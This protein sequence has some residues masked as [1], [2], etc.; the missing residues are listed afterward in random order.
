MK[1]ADDLWGFPVLLLILMWLLPEPV[2]LG[3][4]EEAAKVLVAKGEVSASREGEQFRQIQTGAP[5]YSGE[6]LATGN[7]EAQ[8]RFS[9]GG[10]MT[11]YRNTRFAI[12]DYHFAEKNTEENNADF[13]LIKGLIHTMTGEIGKNNQEKYKL[14]TSM[15]VL[16]VRG[17]DYRMLLGNQLQVSMLDGAVLL[18]NNGG[19]LLINKG[20]NALVNGFNMIPE[21]TRHP[22]NLDPYRQPPPKGALPLG[23]LSLQGSL[24][25]LPL[26][27]PPAPP[28]PPLVHDL[29]KELKDSLPSGFVF[30]PFMP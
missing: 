13:S 29:L 14:K 6:T 4:E 27:L 9:D 22:L 17:T 18:S 20:Q 26:S 10:L 28:P 15:A 12:D 25:P 1:N 7:G 3:A 8:I 21:L 24:P 2:A 23:G 16:G 5:L 19:S 11:L 30:P